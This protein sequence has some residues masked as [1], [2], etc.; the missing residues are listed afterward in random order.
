MKFLL[1]LSNK[2][3][4]GG[5]DFT[6]AEALRKKGG[7]VV[8][9]KEIEEAESLLSDLD[10]SVDEIIIGSFGRISDG[11]WRRVQKAAKERGVGISLLTGEGVRS[12]FEALQ[13]EGVKVIGKYNFNLKNFLGERFPVGGALKEIQ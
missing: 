8:L 2:D 7:E 3:L 11:D 12:D 13:G 9:K 5:W 10:F 6:L 1:V 4:Q